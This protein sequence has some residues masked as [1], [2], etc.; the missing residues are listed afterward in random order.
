[1]PEINRPLMIGDVIRLIDRLGNP[2][3]ETYTVSKIRN[4]AKGRTAYLTSEYGYGCQI[5][6]NNVK[7][8]LVDH[9]GKE[10]KP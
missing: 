10:I 8:E 5:G 4:Y 9:K 7:Y 6:E 2:T 1:M 3:K